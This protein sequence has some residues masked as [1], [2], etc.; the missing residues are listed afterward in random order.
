MK[1]KTEVTIEDLICIIQGCTE[2]IEHQIKELSK[3]ED[4]DWLPLRED[5]LN[6]AIHNRKFW[7]KMLYEKTFN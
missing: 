5:L 6:I 7:I 1:T 4:D 2:D 3:S